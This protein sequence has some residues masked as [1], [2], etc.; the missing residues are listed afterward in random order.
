[1]NL[2]LK[3]YYEDYESLLFNEELDR[4]KFSLSDQNQ[5]EYNI[6]CKKSNG[7]RHSMM[8]KIFVFKIISQNHISHCSA[9]NASQK[10]VFFEN[11]FVIGFHLGAVENRKGHSE[12]L[13][14]SH[15]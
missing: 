3:P 6:L 5:H 12:K 9:T 4:V 13:A 8:C 2:V 15:R 10:T 11:L 7:P 14:N 1:M